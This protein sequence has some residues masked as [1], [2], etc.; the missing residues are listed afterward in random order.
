M[1]VNVRV[2]VGHAAHNMHSDSGQESRDSYGNRD[3]LCSVHESMRLFGG[4]TLLLT[5]Q[6]ED[7][8]PSLT[9]RDL[10]QRSAATPIPWPIR[11]GGMASAPAPSHPYLG[12]SEQGAWHRH[13]PPH[14]PTL[15]YL[16]RGYG[17]GTCPLGA[18][19]DEMPPESNSLSP[20]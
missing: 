12:L 13:L 19:R 16:S 11:A 6:S 8:R 18:G 9:K 4:V 1:W 5:R 20:T 7:Q 15:A 10:D 2:A 14:T 17:I 3:D